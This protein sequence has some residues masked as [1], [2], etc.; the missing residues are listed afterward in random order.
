[1]RG[2]LAKA[3][4]WETSFVQVGFYIKTGPLMVWEAIEAR[5]LVFTV[6]YCVL[7][8]FS[9]YAEIQNYYYY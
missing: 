7:C 4:L 6:T 9:F 1:M 8:F 3:D 2:S 5:K